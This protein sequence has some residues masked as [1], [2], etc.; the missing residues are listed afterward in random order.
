MYV[1]ST[2]MEIKSVPVPYS[3]ATMAQT[4]TNSGGNTRI[5]TG[6]AGLHNGNRIATYID[7]TRTVV[8]NKL[9]LSHV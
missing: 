2:S 4:G 8:D 5:H 9:P 3:P 7:M 6:A 1:M